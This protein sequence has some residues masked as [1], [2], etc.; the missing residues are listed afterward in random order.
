MVQLSRATDETAKG[1]VEI[2]RSVQEINKASEEISEGAS[3][4]SIAANRLV[5]LSLKLGESVSQFK[6]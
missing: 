1:A 5:D 2:S 3:K 6:F 4:T